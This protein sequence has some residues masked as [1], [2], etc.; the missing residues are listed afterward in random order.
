M[1]AEV[2]GWYWHYWREEDVSNKVRRLRSGDGSKGDG[3]ARL[4]ERG[5]GRG[6]EQV[7]W[8]GAGGDTG[9]E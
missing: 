5:R 3:I 8:L 2:K 9:G 7:Q 4:V 1:R 6:W